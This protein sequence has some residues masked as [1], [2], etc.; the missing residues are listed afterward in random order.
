MSVAIVQPAMTKSEMQTLIQFHN[1]VDT[2]GYAPT[3]REISDSLG[4]AS[5][6]GVR[7]NIAK[8]LE[9]SFLIKFPGSIRCISLTAK[10]KDLLRQLGA[11]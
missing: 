5:T 1:L 2:F 10:G 6:N 11:Q 3:L 9:K 7:K 8:L 4:H